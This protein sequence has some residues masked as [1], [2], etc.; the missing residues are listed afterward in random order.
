MKI[1]DLFIFLGEYQLFFVNKDS[2][3]IKVFFLAEV[4]KLDFDN[5]NFRVI[6]N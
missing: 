3:S 6:F 1:Q 2:V 5:F 4:I